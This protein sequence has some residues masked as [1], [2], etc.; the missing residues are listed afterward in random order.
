MNRACTSHGEN[1]NWPQNFAW[2]A[3]EEV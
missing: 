1:K 2:N 3:T